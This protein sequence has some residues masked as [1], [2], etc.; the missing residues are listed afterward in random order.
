MDEKREKAITKEKKICSGAW[1][2]IIPNSRE[3]LHNAQ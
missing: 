2:N 3:Y 1:K